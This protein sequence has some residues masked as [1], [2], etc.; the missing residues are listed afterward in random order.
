[1]LR[2]KKGSSILTTPIIIAIRDINGYSA[3]TSYSG[4]TYTVSLV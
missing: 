2:N 3:C 4:D 1:M